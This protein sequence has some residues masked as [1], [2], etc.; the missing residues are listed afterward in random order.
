MGR[1][2]KTWSEPAINT[3]MK[4]VPPPHT[5]TLETVQTADKIYATNLGYIMKEMK[6]DDRLLKNSISLEQPHFS[7]E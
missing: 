4:K 2:Y 5:T 7:R 3:K 6:H 1:N